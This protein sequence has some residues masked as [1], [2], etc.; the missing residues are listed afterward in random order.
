M[1]EWEQYLHN[2]PKWSCG[3]QE[4]VIECDNGYVWFA[5]TFSNNM[6][7]VNAVE[8]YKVILQQN[9]FRQAGQYPSPNSLYKMVDGVCY[10]VDMEN[11]FEGD[12]N[13]PTIYFSIGEPTGGFNY[14]KPEPKKPTSFRDLFNF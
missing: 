6:T 9:G 7:A 2:Y 8:Q 1:E 14:V 13:C 10:K 12:S 11:M 4:L 5:A 3:G